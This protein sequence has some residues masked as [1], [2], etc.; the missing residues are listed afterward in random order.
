[1][2]LAYSRYVKVLFGFGW[3]LVPSEIWV[4]SEIFNRLESPSELN[5]WDVDV[6]SMLTLFFEVEWM[7]IIPWVLRRV[8]RVCTRGFSR[9]CSVEVALMDITSAGSGSF[10]CDGEF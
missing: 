5:F 4:P 2:G 1:M 6:L 3:G 8:L 9:R 10:C 7:G